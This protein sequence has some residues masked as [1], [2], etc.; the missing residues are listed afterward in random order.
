MSNIS[1]LF[2]LTGKIV[3]VTGGAQGLG[4][5]IAE[6][7]VKAGAHVFITSRKAD[8]VETAASELRAFG[9]CTGIASDL[10]T[11]ESVR[12]LAD[13]IKARTDRL[14][15]VVN[16][17]GKTWGAPLDGFPD[18]AWASVMAVNVQMPFTLIRDLL[19]LLEASGTAGDPA[20]ILNIGSAAGKAV[21]PLPAFSYA[22]SKAAIHHLS[23]VLAKELAPRNIAVNVIIPGYFP[24]KMTSHIRAE[25]NKL[26]DTLA[27]IPMNRLGSA[28]DI[29]GLCIFLASRASSYITGAE[30]PLDGGL[31]GC[32]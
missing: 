12:E 32:R 1:P 16:N 29:Q 28:E 26:A 31:T 8:I 19:G 11:P 10:S 30:L 21:E 27:H 14:H 9:A 25:D 17:A 13:A 4:R 2:D 20:R 18:S 6:G 7:Y 15:V 3:L 23:R 24:T 5:M 22:A